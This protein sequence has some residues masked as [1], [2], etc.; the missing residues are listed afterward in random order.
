MDTLTDA[1]KV[2]T[3]PYLY[4]CSY[5]RGACSLIMLKACCEVRVRDSVCVAATLREAN[6]RELVIGEHSRSC[7]QWDI[8]EVRATIHSRYALPSLACSIDMRTPQLSYM[9]LL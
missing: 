8:W 9:D 1:S 3:T 5:V 6:Y 7:G 4:L 2:R